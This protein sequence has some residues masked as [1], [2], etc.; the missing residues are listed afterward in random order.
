MKKVAIGLVVFVVVLG[1]ALVVGPGLIDWNSHT[2]RIA[3]QIEKL[4]GRKVTIAGDVRLQLIPRPQ[5]AVSKVSLSN[6]PGAADT[7]MASLDS[8]EVRV[9]AV[10]LLTGNVKVE[11]VKL[12]RPVVHLER[13]ADGR[14]NWE[15]KAVE[16]AGTAP[17]KPAAPAGAKP[18]DGKAGGVPAVAVDSFTIENGTMTLRDAAKGTVERLTGIDAR[19]AAAS[20]EGPIESDGK[21]TFRGMRLAY[22]ANVAEMIRGRTVPVNLRLGI[23]EDAN[24]RIGG[25]IVGLPDAPKLRGKLSGDGKSVAGLID[26]LAGPGKAPPGLAKAFALEG[27]VEA[28]AAGGR[29]DNLRLRLGETDLKVSAAVT[30][31]DVLDLRADVAAGWIDLDAWLAS[32]AP[33]A[34]NAAG[35]NAGTSGDKPAAA[36]KKAPAAAPAGN[37]L[38][39]LFPLPQGVRGSLSVAVD[40]LVHRRQ[41]VRNASLSVELVD[42]EITL[43]QLTAQLP[44]GTDVG[45]FGFLSDKNG[46]PRFEGQ[47]EARADNLRPVLAWLGGGG[48]L[49]KGGFEKFAFKTPVIVDGNYAWLTAIDSRL[50]GSRAT[51]AVTLA[52]AQRP[53]FGADLTV[54]KVNLDAYLGTQKAKAAGGAKPGVA[55]KAGDAASGG[56]TAGAGT[57]NPLAALKVLDTFDANVKAKVGSAV[58]QGHR[59]TG[60]AVDAS[61]LRGVLTLR[62]LKVANAAGLSAS[63]TGVLS[64]L[65]ATPNAKALRVRV[66][67]RDLTAFQRMTGLTLPVP[68]KQLGRVA[69]DATV[70]GPLLSPAVNMNASAAGGDVSVK[71]QL[72]VL[73]LAGATS[74]SN[75]RPSTAIS[76]SC[77]GGWASPTSRPAR[78]AGS[79]WRGTWSATSRPCGWKT[80]RVGSVGSRRRGTW[81]ST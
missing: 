56:K 78:S 70:N 53:S 34:E 69:M 39:A 11:T 20:L 74:I 22:S 76:R 32:V 72:P 57:T 33:K 36:K 14:V 38:A 10:P 15:F 24:V 71:G 63:A 49:P 50:N 21:V 51:G 67:A 75:G 17:A 62:Q 54:D 19:I 55:N 59:I 3:A 30:T 52:L 61:L 77:C 68:A 5:L 66:S 46:K 58:Y 1:I 44:G 29:V 31:G 42:G 27:D 80:S 45:V 73:A 48:D 40:S 41:V 8:L 43:N 7:L 9:A 37:P 26:A 13:L 16:A 64:D 4:T 81:R 28:S 79:I 12:V 47:V 25:S 65:A 6:L 2:D 23:G 18:G 60:L 35:K